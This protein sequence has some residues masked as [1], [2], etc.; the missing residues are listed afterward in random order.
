M[1]FFSAIQEFINTFLHFFLAYWLFDCFWSKK[2]QPCI[3]VVMLVLTGFLCTPFFL[4]CKGSPLQL[5]ALFAFTVVIS[6]LFQTKLINK[7]LCTAIFFVL[8]AAI[9]MMVAFFMSSLFHVE[10]ITIKEG[11]LYITGMLFS[12][13]VTFL[14]IFL[15]RLKRRS[16]LFQIIRKNNFSVFAFPLATLVIILLQH[17][18][19]IYYP[20]Q[21]TFVSIAVLVCYSVLI[22]A[23]ILIFEFIDTLYKNTMYETKITAANE[24]IAKQIHQYETVLEHHSEIVKMRHDQKN[25]CIGVLAELKAGNV[26]SVTKKLE[27]EYANLNSMMEKPNDI[28]HTLVAIKN[29]IAV[30]HGICIDFEY[31][32]LGQLVIPAIDLAVILGNALDNAI[33]ATANVS[34]HTRR[35]IHFLTAVKNKSIVI[36]IKNPVDKKLDVENLRT[37]KEKS[38]M[39]GYGI[40]SMKQI[41]EKYNGEVTFLCSD[42]EFTTSIFLSNFC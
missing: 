8:N 32:D 4:C 14:L 21:N 26:E 7:L 3:T 16:S 41:A 31:R 34:D 24:L 19:F 11:V 22:V 20:V 9:E 23:N 28:V 18:I 12:K 17:G 35:T 42:T 29:E 39:H 15:I 6:W 38:A 1:L 10:L 13:F 27:E 5:V 40:I 2:Y 36:T 25:F 37:T 30:A 33:E